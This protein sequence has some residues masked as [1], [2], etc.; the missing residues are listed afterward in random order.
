MTAEEARRADPPAWFVETRHAGSRPPARQPSRLR[1][2][3]AVER[4]GRVVIVSSLFLLLIAAAVVTG[5]HNAVDP[6]VR[7]V[8]AARES[9]S[10][11]DIVLTMP[12]GI[13]CRHMSFDN[14]TAELIAGSM[15]PCGPDLVSGRSHAESKFSW[16]SR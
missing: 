4:S 8:I 10:V 3:G 12:D 1:S 5:G 13:Y 7:S 16:G 6:L 14:A 11:G 2:D 9:R 15:K